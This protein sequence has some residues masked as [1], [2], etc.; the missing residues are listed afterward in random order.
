MDAQDG[1]EDT[2]TSRGF[3]HTPEVLGEYGGHVKVYESSGASEPQVWL[4]A[5]S[6]EG[7]E[8]HVLLTVDNALVLAENLLRLR[9]L[10]YQ[11]QGD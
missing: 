5:Q 7:T 3:R 10:H 11:R 4:A 8:A 6:P 2:I 1:T 9:R